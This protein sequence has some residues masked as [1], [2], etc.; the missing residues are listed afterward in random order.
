MCDWQSSRKF[1]CA[2]SGPFASAKPGKQALTALIIPGFSIPAFLPGFLIPSEHRFESKAYGSS[3]VPQADCI[4][5]SRCGGSVR[6]ISSNKTAIVPVGPGST[7]SVIA[8]VVQLWQNDGLVAQLNETTRKVVVWQQSLYRCELKPS[9]NPSGTGVLR[10]ASSRNIVV[11][12]WKEMVSKSIEESIAQHCR[13]PQQK[14][15]RSV[16]SLEGIL[17]TSS[18]CAVTASILRWTRWK[19]KDLHEN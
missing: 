1:A 10:R 4:T 13:Q 9:R 14:T 19:R 18:I 8:S 6:E 7:T 12:S 5:T 11:V 2:S 17:A 15:D 16:D 3:R